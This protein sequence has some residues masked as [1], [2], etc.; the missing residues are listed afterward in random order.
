MD[1][2]RFAPE[3]MKHKSVKVFKGESIY[4]NTLFLLYMY[5]YSIKVIF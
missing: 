2:S 5:F 1:D 3:L 4:F